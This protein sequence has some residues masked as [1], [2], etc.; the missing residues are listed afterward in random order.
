MDLTLRETV[1]AGDTLRNDYCVINDG[2]S[3]GWIYKAHGLSGS[4]IWAWNINPPLPIPSWCNGSADS[5]EA[6]KDRFKAA[7]ERFYASL[8]PQDIESWHRIED[9]AKANA[10][11]LK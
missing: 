2:R 9:A 7:W 5:F 6:A 3:V 11:W 4:T 1:I 10:G 8:T